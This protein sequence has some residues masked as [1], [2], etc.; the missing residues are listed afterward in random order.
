M[1]VFRHFL[2]SFL[3]AGRHD[4]GDSDPGKR[5]TTT[6]GAVALAQILVGGYEFGEGA[7]CL[8]QALDAERRRICRRF[9]EVG[10]GHAGGCCRACCGCIVC[11]TFEPFLTI[12]A[13]VKTARAFRS[14]QMPGKC[15]S[16]RPG[17]AGFQVAATTVPQ[18]LQIRFNTLPVAS[19]R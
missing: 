19:L 2:R 3:W 7:V 8:G 11:H 4:V 15:Q 10:V 17:G 5:V 6:R 9:R 16:K 18:F 12:S 13:A 14:Q 1:F